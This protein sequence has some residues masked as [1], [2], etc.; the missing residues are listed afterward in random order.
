LQPVPVSGVPLPKITYD[1]V[2][3]DHYRVKASG[4]HGPFLLA[5]NEAFAKGWHLSGLPHNANAQH[6]EIDGYR[7]GWAIDARGNLELNLVYA[8][9]RAGHAARLVSQLTLLAL[10]LSVLATPEM[11]RRRKR[12]MA[13][14]AQAGRPGPRRIVLPDSWPEPTA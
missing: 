13:R 7:N 8:P 14:R 10:G 12:F 5:L 11:A 3:S 6:V 1:K 2:S 9:A 4:A